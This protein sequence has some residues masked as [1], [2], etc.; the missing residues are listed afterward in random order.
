MR[1]AF[2]FKLLGNLLFCLLGMGLLFFSQYF[3]IRLYLHSTDDSADLTLALT[4]AKKFLVILLF[5]L[6]FFAISQAYGS[7]LREMGKT[8]VPMFASS[9]AV[10]TNTAL[11]FLLIFGLFSSLL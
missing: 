9:I 6:P 3:L 5:S 10:V 7:S 4:S 8:M 1:D 2:R 11:N